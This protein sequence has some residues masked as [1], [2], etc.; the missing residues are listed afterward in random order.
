MKKFIFPVVFALAAGF[1]FS[2]C[3]GDDE[4]LEEQQAELTCK[5]ERI[6]QIEALQLIDPRSDA[7]QAELDAFYAQLEAEAE[8]PN[9]TC[10]G[11]SG[12]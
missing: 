3:G 8:D 2:G 10:L 5:Q 7:Q 12:T 1:G 11:G 4:G 6:D 9:L